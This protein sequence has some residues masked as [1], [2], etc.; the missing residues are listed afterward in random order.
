MKTN[1]SKGNNFASQEISCIVAVTT[2][3]MVLVKRARHW[4]TFWWNGSNYYAQNQRMSR[5]HN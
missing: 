2:P 4:P 5:W 3:F 1:T